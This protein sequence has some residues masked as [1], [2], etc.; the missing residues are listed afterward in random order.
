MRR[1]TWQKHLVISK[2][3]GSNSKMWEE[4]SFLDLVIFFPNPLYPF[5]RWNTINRHR[6]PCMHK[7]CIRCI[8]AGSDIFIDT[9]QKW[10][11][12][13]L[14]IVLIS[15]T[16]ISIAFG[17]PKKQGVFDEP[18]LTKQVY[19]KLK[20]NGKSK[21]VSYEPV[22]IHIWCQ[23]HI[24]TCNSQQYRKGKWTWNFHEQ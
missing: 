8:W 15:G 18:C 17:Q 21:Q 1:S 11:A 20:W 24:Y 19:T 16:G 12:P 4:N 22:Q 3:S 9:L 14:R 13:D 23:K 2:V 6:F 7:E 5:C 10:F